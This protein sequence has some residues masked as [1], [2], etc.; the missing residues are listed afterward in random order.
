[1]IIYLS[2]ASILFPIIVGIRKF[3]LADKAIK[4]F[5]FYLV[6][7]LF[8][9][10]ICVVMAR[11]KMNNLIVI[12]L[13]ALVQSFLLPVILLSWIQSRR[14]KIVMYTVVAFLIAAFMYR[15]YSGGEQREF[16]SILIPLQNLLFVILTIRVLIADTLETLPF[17][18][19]LWICGALFFNFSVSIVIFCTT[20]LMAIDTEF[21][22]K[23]LWYLNSIINIITNI[24]FAIGLLC[25][26]PK[27]T[28]YLQSL[29]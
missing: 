18:Y 13:F 6:L 27:M 21:A 24:L 29:S 22:Q 20:N 9:D 16:D 3:A 2:L 14:F 11:N 1:M 19:K 8:A 17:N 28:S 12:N 15:F 4:L 10:V 25:I 5:V 26:K 23:F 7:G